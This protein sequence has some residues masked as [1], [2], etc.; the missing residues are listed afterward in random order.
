VKFQAVHAVTI[1]IENNQEEEETTKLAKL[2][3]MGVSGEK[4]NVSEIKKVEDGP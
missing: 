3:F 1:F 2:Q 4:M